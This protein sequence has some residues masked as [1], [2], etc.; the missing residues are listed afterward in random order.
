MP[1]SNGPSVQAEGRKASGAPRRAPH[2]LILA[3]RLTALG[4]CA[5]LVLCCTSARAAEPERISLTV[6]TRSLSEVPWKG[7]GVQWSPYPWFELTD[8]DWTRVEERL[9]YMKPPIARVMTRAYKYCEGYDAAGK[10]IYAWGNAR[11]KRMERLLN[12]CEK[13]GVEV[14]LGEWDDPASP[15]DRQDPTADKLKP[16]G[17]EE[18]DPRWAVLICDMLEHF[19]DE[20]NYTCIKWFNLINE[21]NGGWSACADF[22]KWKKGIENL[23]AEMVKRGLDKRVGIIG[24][25]AN[26]QKDYWWLDLNVLQL[27]KQTAMYDLHEYAKKEDVESGHLERVFALKRDYANRYDPAGRRKPFVMGEI[28]LVS[29]LGKDGKPVQPKG[30]RDSQPFIY[31]FEYGVWMADYNAQVARAGMDGTCAWAV[32]DAM[33][34]QK[35]P[36]STWPKLDNVELKKWGFWNSMAEEI[37]HPEDAAIRPWFYTW[38]VMSRAYPAGCRMLEIPGCLPK[39]LR[40]L[41]ARWEHHG[42][43][44]FSLTVINDSDTARDVTIAVPEAAWSSTVHRFHY[45]KDDRPADAD[46]FPVVK[47]IDSGVDL[48]KGVAVSLP[49]RGVVVLT[50]IPISRR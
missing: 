49:S 43:K 6:G 44:H 31:D 33:H 47:Q 29:G 40:P 21:P 45:F 30:G 35:N 8:A 27:A 23:H 26:A 50:T 10:P 37:G 36:D 22:A 16:Y 1:E 28:G 34:I 18:T 41:A 12:F 46:G 38:A 25:D 2:Q 39:G 42:T 15:E 5:M 20:K 14:I 9:A 17:I 13:H 3:P 24:P 19:L 48:S 11:M 4:L 32:D 7:F